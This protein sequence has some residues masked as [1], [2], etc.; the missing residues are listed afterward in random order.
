VVDGIVEQLGERMTHQPLHFGW[1][2]EARGKVLPPGRVLL[3]GG[4]RIALHDLT[5]RAGSVMGSS[6]LAGALQPLGSHQRL[7]LGVGGTLRDAQALHQVLG[8][9]SAVLER[10]GRDPRGQR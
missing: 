8:Q 2:I 5:Q 6:A 4:Q 9:P 7:E 3:Q 1:Q 10:G